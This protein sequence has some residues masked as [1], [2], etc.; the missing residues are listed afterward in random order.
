MLRE[1]P[2]ETSQPVDQLE[3]SLV[4]HLTGSVTLLVEN[5]PDPATVA[6]AFL[7]IVDTCFKNCCLYHNCFRDCCL[8]RVFPGP[9]P[10]RFSYRPGT[11][12]A[13]CS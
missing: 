1:R 3:A 6:G 2:L 12:P 4:Q 9:K 7:A 8:I 5:P 11:N 13:R 10:S